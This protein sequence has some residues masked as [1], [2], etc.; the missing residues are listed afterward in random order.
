LKRLHKNR[1]INSISR[2]CVAS[3]SFTI[4]TSGTAPT[5]NSVTLQTGGGLLIAGTSSTFQT[6]GITSGSGV[7]PTQ[8]GTFNVSVVEHASKRIRWIGNG[9]NVFSKRREH[10]YRAL[11][12]PM[13]NK[14]NP[15]EP[16]QQHG[17]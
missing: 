12:I 10:I 8:D 4:S 14:P 5:T 7:T 13:K 9:N 16:D 15:R 1:N 17:P 6:S 11:C 3:T 2:V